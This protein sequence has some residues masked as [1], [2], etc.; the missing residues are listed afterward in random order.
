MFRVKQV[1]T[2]LLLSALFEL[3]CQGD[4]LAY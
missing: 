2:G 4:T 1:L 3:V